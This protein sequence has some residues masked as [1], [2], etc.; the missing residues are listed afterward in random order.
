M[1]STYSNEKNKMA[2]QYNMAEELFDYDCTK[3]KCKN[4]FKKVGEYLELQSSEIKE[5]KTNITN[6]QNELNQKITNIQKELSE[7]KEKLSARDIATH[8]ETKIMNLIFPDCKKRPFQLHS[9]D[10]LRDFLNNPEL[11]ERQSKCLRGTAK[12]WNAISLPER[13]KILQNWENFEQKNPNVVYGIKLL[14]K[15]G[16]N[17]AHQTTNFEDTLAYLRQT[18]EELADRL[19][20]LREFI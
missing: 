19:E 4:I 18:D 12:A 11:S 7:F 1:I 14:K 20:E 15:E 10:N 9:L 16:N 13:T 5:L 3:E 17:I 2:T 6:I 8:A